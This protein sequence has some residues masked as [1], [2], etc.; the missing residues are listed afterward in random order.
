M[1]MRT[2]ARY[3]YG[4]ATE[5]VRCP[6]P[7]AP[8]SP[9]TPVIDRLKRCDRFAQSASMI[10]TINWQGSALSKDNPQRDLSQ[11]LKNR[12]SV[13]PIDARSKTVGAEPH[14]MNSRDGPLKRCVY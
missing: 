13:G 14:P 8:T 9:T 6:V 11:E 1:V 2:R 3:H 7:S 12:P 5:E 4:A 10:T